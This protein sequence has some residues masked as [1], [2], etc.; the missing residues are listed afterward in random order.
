MLIRHVAI[1]DAQ[2]ESIGGV[3][4][5]PWPT[6]CTAVDKDTKAEFLYNSLALFISQT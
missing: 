5:N 1:G 2:R 6:D 4:G 3:G